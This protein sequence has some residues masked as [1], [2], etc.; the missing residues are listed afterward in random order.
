MPFAYCKISLHLPECHSLKQKRSVL[1]TLMTKMRQL[2][3]SVIESAQQDSWQ[4]ATLDLVLVAGSQA[5][6]DQQL[7]EVEKII[8]KHFLQ[9]Q[10]LNFSKESYLS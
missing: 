3:I 6:L 5:I 9:V 8:T 4:F 10:L 2:D 7:A 1:A